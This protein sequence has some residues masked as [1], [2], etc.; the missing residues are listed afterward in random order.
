MLFFFFLVLSTAA[1]LSHPAPARNEE[2]GSQACAGCHAEIYRKYSA[3]G[4]A[5][6]S[7]RTATDAFHESFEHAG[8]SDPASGAAYRVAPSAEGYRLEFSRSAAGVRGERTL[9]WFIGS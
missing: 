3:T 9:E 2:I 7:G 6:T 8:F 1:A 5:R 4:M